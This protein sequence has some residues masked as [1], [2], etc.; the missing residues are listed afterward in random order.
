MAQVSYDETELIMI[1]AA[2]I[3][4]FLTKLCRSMNHTKLRN[5]TREWLNRYIPA[6]IL[7]TIGALIAAWAV[8]GQTHSYIAAAAAGWVGEGVG[9]YGYFVTTELLLNSKKYRQ[10]P[11]M[12]RVSLAVA[13]ASTNLLIEFL[14]AEILDNFMLRPFLMYLIPQYVHPYPVGFLVGKFSADI[15][16]YAL[17]I[18]GYE[19]RK[20]YLH[21]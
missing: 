9:F 2:D 12:K 17:A 18:I 3:W 14:P 7:G 21:R 19:V 13:T 10:Y 16:F 6:E 4:T 15:L 8:Y 5:K 20:H 1:L 11:L